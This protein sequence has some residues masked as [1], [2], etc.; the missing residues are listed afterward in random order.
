M[1]DTER[2]DSGGFTPA[3]FVSGTIA[4]VV[5]VGLVGAVI[6]WARGRSVDSSI[7]LAYYFVGSI[8][9]LV[10]SFPSGG[11]SL[12]RGKTRRRPIGGGAFA[13]PSMLLGA[14]LIGVGVAF[15]LTHPF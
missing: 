8:V 9:F 14:L 3:I 7:A 11:F 1:D 2:D 15:D 12:I 5:V 13:V 6:A 10:G 4:S